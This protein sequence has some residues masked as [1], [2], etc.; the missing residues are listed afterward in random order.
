M[1]PRPAAP[2]AR[3]AP[4]AALA[5]VA[6]LAAAPTA[7]AAEAPSAEVAAWEAV[8]AW[9]EEQRA[10]YQD[11]PGWLL[12][13][14]ERADLVAM[15]AAERGAWMEGFLSDPAFAAAV[16]VRREL[17]FSAVPSP[18]DVRARLLF[19]HGPPAERLVVDCGLTF[20]PLEVWT[21]GDPQAPQRAGSVHS[22]VVYEDGAAGGWRLWLPR[23]G[24]RVL[25]TRQMEH[26]LEDWE[27]LVGGGVLR[28]RRFDLQACRETRRVDRVTGVRGLT[29]ADADRPREEDFLALLAP[30]A[31]LAAWTRQALA[32][33]PPPPPALEVRGAEVRF[34][35]RVA[36]LARALDVPA[37]PR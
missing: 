22:V 7:P 12:T 29:D 15:E 25:Y 28:A 26:W 32:G 33:A 8:L 13:E 24:K 10:F 23:H 18:T 21:W 14:A 20:G 16:A 17:A 19:L 31:D 37:E 4:V 1:K 2:A 27:E 36:R 9:P 5:A 3:F 35:G 30:P 34:P 6:V 11:G